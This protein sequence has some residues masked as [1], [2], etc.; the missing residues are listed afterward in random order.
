MSARM[1]YKASLQWLIYNDDCHWL[2]DEHGSISVTTAFVAD[3]FDK[4]DEQIT[5]DLRKARDKKNQNEQS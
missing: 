4:T 3:M 2:D 1:G 5:A